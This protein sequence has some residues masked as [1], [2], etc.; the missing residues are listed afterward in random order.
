MRYKLIYQT[1]VGQIEFSLQSGYIIGRFDSPTRQNVEM[2][3]TSGSRSIGEKLESQQVSG[4]LMTISGTLKGNDADSK[5]KKMLHIIAPLM[6]GTLIL[7]DKYV[8]E[9]Y[10][11]ETPTVERYESN[12]EFQFIIFA[13]YPYWRT[14]NGNTAMLLGLQKQFHFPWNISDPNPFRFS[15]YTKNAYTNVYNSGDAPTQ[16]KITFLA[17]STLRNPIVENIQTGEFVRVLCTLEAGE[18]VVV[19]TMGQEITVTM[20]AADGTETDGFTHLDIDSTA[21][22]LAVGDN[23]LKTQAEATDYALHAMMEYRTNIAGV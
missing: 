1:D 16:W 21:F 23:L 8:M 9:V 3:T 18:Q 20:I 19:D 11:K 5:R 12:P 17:K 14:K 15:T 7:D 10:P 6:K 4:K 2:H 22:Q 13:P